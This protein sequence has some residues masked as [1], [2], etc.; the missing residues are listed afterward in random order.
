MKVNVPLHTV[1]VI[2]LLIIAVLMI[3]GIKI[4]IGFFH[5]GNHTVK[6]STYNGNGPCRLTLAI[7]GMQCGHCEANI[8]DAIREHFTINKVSSNHTKGETIIIAPQ[9]IDEIALK[10]TITESGYTLVGISKENY[11]K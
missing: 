5:E 11:R 8:N 1:D 3:G 9:D 7:N 6:E 4:V 10:N 2:I